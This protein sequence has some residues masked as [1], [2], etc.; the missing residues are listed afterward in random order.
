MLHLLPSLINS[1]KYEM[2]EKVLTTKADTRQLGFPIS[3]SNCCRLFEYRKQGVGNAHITFEHITLA[4]KYTQE[5]P[6]LKS[7]DCATIFL[8]NKH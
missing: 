8:L 7:L 4:E 6:N 1:S 2:K 5:H 3:L